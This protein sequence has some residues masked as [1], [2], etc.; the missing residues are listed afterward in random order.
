MISIKYNKKP[1]LCN[2]YQQ[3]QCFPN[4]HQW[5]W[6]RVNGILLSHEA[7]HWVGKEGPF[8]VRIGKRNEGI[9]KFKAFNHSNPV[10]RST[11]QEGSV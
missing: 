3:K 2:T 1:R 4:W 7:A 9:R 6:E 11:E 10:H 5:G 8:K